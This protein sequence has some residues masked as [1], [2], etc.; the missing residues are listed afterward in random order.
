MLIID[1]V[2]TASRMEYHDG[3]FVGLTEDGKVAKTLFVFMVNSMTS[4]YKD[5]VKLIPFDRLTSKEL[6]ILMKS[7]LNC[8]KS[9]SWYWLY[10]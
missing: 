8:T 9:V 3:E 6:I 5:V 10:Q 1:E 7:W 2:Y 4:K